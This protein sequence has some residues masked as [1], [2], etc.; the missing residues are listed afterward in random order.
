MGDSVISITL[1]EWVKLTY[2]DARKGVIIIGATT[3]I[4]NLSANGHYFSDPIGT[5]MGACDIV[6][7]MLVMEGL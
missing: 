4:K 6:N 3:L 2:G 1:V 5:F 7:S